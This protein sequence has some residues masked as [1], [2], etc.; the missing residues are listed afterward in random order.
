MRIRSSLGESP[1]FSDYQKLLKA[2]DDKG[3][4]GITAFFWAEHVAQPENGKFSLQCARLESVAIPRHEVE[5]VN[6]KPQLTGPTVFFLLWQHRHKTQDNLIVCPCV[7]AKEK[8]C[9]LF[10]GVKIF[11]STAVPSQFW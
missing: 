8:T 9:L 2:I 11:H 7:H 6:S 4:S 3:F 10:S 5:R 1:L